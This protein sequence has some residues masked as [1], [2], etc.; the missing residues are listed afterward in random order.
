MCLLSFH[1]LHAYITYVLTFQPVTYS[2][3]KFVKNFTNR[4]ARYHRTRYSPVRQHRWLPHYD[5]FPVIKHI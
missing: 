4:L 5:Q 2:Y 1:F 3:E